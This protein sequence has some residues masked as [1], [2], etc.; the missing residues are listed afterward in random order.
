MRHESPSRSSFRLLHKAI[1]YLIA[2]LGLGALCLGDLLS[3]SFKIGLV[4][5]VASSWFV[6]GSVLRSKRYQ[7]LWSALL[8]GAFILQVLRGTSGQALLLVAVEFSAFLQI[9]R[10]FNRLGAREAQQITV[11]AFLHL[12]AATVLTTSISYAVILIGFVILTP[13]MLTLSYMRYEAERAYKTSEPALLH[14]LDSTGIVNPR[15]MLGTLGLVV[16]MLMMT[17]LLFVA[18]PRVGL[19]LFSFGYGARQRV[20]GFGGQVDLGEFGTIRED[21]TV[22]I[23][24]RSSKDGLLLRPESLRLRGTSFDHYDGRRWSRT[25]TELSR[26]EHVGKD[27]PVLRWPSAEDIAI[28]VELEPIDESVIFLPQNTVAL[29]IAPRIRAG[30]ETH[31]HIT[32]AGGL[33]FRFM[34]GTDQGLHYV[35]LLSRAPVV[36]DARWPSTLERT[37]YLQLPS[38]HERLVSLAT[39]VT[40]GILS[41]RDKVIALQTY[42]QDASR[43][44][45]NTGSAQD[46]GPRPLEHFLF[47][48][49]SGHCEYFASALAIMLRGVGIPSRHVTGFLGGRYN[50]YGRYIAV[51]QGD[52]HSWVEAY[53]DGKG[54]M[55]FD[56]TPSGRAA[57]NV[58]MGLAAQIRAAVDAL[59]S[60]WDR[61]VVSYDLKRQ[62]D[63]WN[64]LRRWFDSSPRGD[65]AP[66][67]ARKQP[68]AGRAFGVSPWTVGFAILLVLGGVLVYR[69]PRTRKR[70]ASKAAEQRHGILLYREMERW[71]EQHDVPRP[72]SVTPLQHVHALRSQAF[73]AA[74]TVQRVTDRYMLARYARQP[75]S[76]EEHKRLVHELRRSST[77]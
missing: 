60:R 45:Y 23:R 76:P 10:L 65:A 12:I 72:P 25:D 32:R 52:A 63:T 53:I 28:P 54:W 71:L 9:T 47:V 55:S 3:T 14:A 37:R 59:R 6:E 73:S 31:R 33:E 5:A 29:Q 67:L 74:E 42:L 70:G 11:L 68:S 75:L 16:P 77:V 26:A 62:L 20:A 51:R 18:F 48:S 58:E 44:S 49:K 34:D 66:V 61:Q 1:S 30:M 27:Y 39:Q 46:P 35:A 8:V 22:V 36:A 17:G 41:D 69:L 43:F 21:P 7:Q 13:W 19:G 40:K 24:V 15:F 57:V 4:V 50:P 64:R 56:P 38:G 2:S